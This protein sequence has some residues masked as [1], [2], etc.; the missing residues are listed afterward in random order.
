LFP[1]ILVIVSQ[2]LAWGQLL[3]LPL[4]LSITQS[5]PSSNFLLVYEVIYPIIFAMVVFLNPLAMNFYESDEGDNFGTRIGWSFLYAFIITAVWSA[6][7][8]IS[9]VWLGVYTYAGSEYRLDAAL[10]IF[11]AMSLVGWILLAFNGGIGLAYLP[12]DLI[13]YFVYR[14]KHLT[15]EEALAKK[16]GLQLKSGELITSGEKLQ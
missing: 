7:V 15:A 14:P 1:K 10:Y 12:F 4:D 11:L 5:D 3:L 16:Q 9:Y 13:A 2:A 8:F 6:L